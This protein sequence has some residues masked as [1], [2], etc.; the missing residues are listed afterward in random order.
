MTPM[1]R[2]NE[3]ASPL[4]MAW[5]AFGLVASISIAIQATGAVG[6][7]ALAYRRDAIASGDLWRLVSGAWV[8]LSWAHLALNLAGWACLLI[9]FARLVRPWRQAILL[10]LIAPCTGVILFAAFDSVQWMVG[11]SGPLHGLF[12]VCAL[13][14]LAARDRQDRGPWWRGP[15]FGW[16]LLTGLAVKLAGERGLHG[17]HQEQGPPG[18]LGGPVLPEA[19]VAGALA[20]VIVWALWRAVSVQHAVAA[21]AE[22]GERE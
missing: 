22:R 9:M 7:D 15:R 18:W 21:Q 6:A 13:D 5:P 10:G 19:H 8:H 4:R 17:P 16:V 12:A 20:G 1:L 3:W 2:C 14:L 11:L